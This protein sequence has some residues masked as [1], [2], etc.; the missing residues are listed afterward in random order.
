M[1][2]MLLDPDL[3]FSTRRLNRQRVLEVLLRRGPIS[4]ADLAKRTRLSPP[5]VSALVDEL[6]NDVGLLKEVGIGRSSGGRPPVMLAFNAE[7]GQ[8]VGVDIGSRKLRVMLTDLQGTVLA[9]HEERTDAGSQASTMKQIHRGIKHVYAAAGR[10]VRKLLAIGVAA[11]G[12][13]D[14]RRGVIIS[15][16]NLPGWVNVPLGEMLGSHYGTPVHVDNDANLAALGERWRGAA[17]GVDNFVF[18]ALGAG[19]GAGIVTGGRLQHGHH[20]YAGEIAHMNLDYRE[21]Q[22]D[23]GDSGYLESKIS[24]AAIPRWA[25]A[26]ALLARL[27]SD[28]DQALA[29]IFDA[30]RKDDADARAIVGELA[31]Y[32][33]TAVANLIAVL[34]PALVVFGG[35]LSHAGALLLDPVRTIVTRLVPNVPALS[36]ST[37]GDDA[38]VLGA[39]YSAME[40]AETH[41]FRISSR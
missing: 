17:I 33:G 30:A 13:T 4:R 3:G 34:D 41:L 37:L 21:W 25:R 18:L 32:V 6:V 10:N 24:T 40:L 22:V 27:G 35:G 2:P 15:A 23:F 12:M 11:P 38:Q 16:G 14:V 1:H 29:T 39:V 7:F 20:W 9:R 28:G 26:Q 19:V 8:L 31:V 5:T 36:T